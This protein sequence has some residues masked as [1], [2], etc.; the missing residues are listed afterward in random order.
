MIGSLITQFSPFI[1]FSPNLKFLIFQFLLLYISM[2]LILG[3]SRILWKIL[4]ICLSPRK[5]I[6]EGE[7]LGGG[8]RYKKFEM[9]VLLGSQFPTGRTEIFCH[10]VTTG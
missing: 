3:L 7:F 4:K 10:G 2:K 9:W 8:I 5:K 6:F 1:N